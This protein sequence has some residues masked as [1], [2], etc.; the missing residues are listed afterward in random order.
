MLRA[1]RLPFLALVSAL[2]AGAPSAWSEDASQWTPYS[3]QLLRSDSADEQ[4]DDLEWVAGQVPIFMVPMEK[5]A[6]PFVRIEANI[7]RQGWAFFY[8]N[9]LLKSSE[10]RA[11]RISLEVPLM[12][13]RTQVEIVGS[14]QIVHLEREVILIEFPEWNTLLKKIQ[15][16]THDGAPPPTLAAE[17]GLQSAGGLS[18]AA[19][20]LSTLSAQW[21]DG[22]RWG[23]SF[24]TAFADKT[25][26]ADL[27]LRL[28]WGQGRW[29]LAFGPLL[30]CGID[31]GT[32]SFVALGPQAAFTYRLPLGTSQTLAA[33]LRAAFLL[34][35]SNLTKPNARLGGGLAWFASHPELAGIFLRG[36]FELT[37]FQG[38]PAQTALQLTLGY[39]II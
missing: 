17:A 18:G 6:Q 25:L 24:E 12:G 4:I 34:P 2:L 9:R 37:S 32:S 14:Q 3:A 33:A 27:S 22:W 10:D 19:I 1:P 8:D 13:Q 26:D 39:Q 35:Q 15:R 38:D 30:A 23:L 29:T 5:G 31:R 28:P 11:T 36:D 21:G 7:K 20:R 16:M